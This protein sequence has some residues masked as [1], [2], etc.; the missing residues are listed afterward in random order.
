MD[1]ITEYHAHLQEETVQLQ[2]VRVREE[3]AKAR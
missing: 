2:N 3:G 1:N